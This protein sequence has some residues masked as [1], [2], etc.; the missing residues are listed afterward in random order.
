MAVRASLVWSDANGVSRQTV[1]TTTTGASGIWTAVQAASQAQIDTE[2]E[3]ALGPQVGASATGSYQ[4]VRVSAQ[5]MFQ[6]GSGSILRLTIPAPSAGIFLADKQTV[7]PANT[8][9]AAIVTA[10]LGTLS[11]AAGNTAVAFLGG[12]LQPGRN[13]LPPVS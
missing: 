11:D 12:T 1:V 9:V 7:D 3:S 10:C 13:D 8:L 2:W 4:S 5:L 6:T